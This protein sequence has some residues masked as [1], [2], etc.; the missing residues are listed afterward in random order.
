[1]ME[2]A[3][4]SR[5]APYMKDFVAFKRS[6]GWK[7]ETGEFYLREFD[8]FCAKH[9]SEGVS[10]KEIVRSWVS[11]RETECSNTQRIRVAPIREFGKYLQSSGNSYAFVIPNKVDRKSVV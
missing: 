9:E 2:K 5:L 7:Y 11:L 8:R 10:L 6:L 3:Y 1:M 4:V